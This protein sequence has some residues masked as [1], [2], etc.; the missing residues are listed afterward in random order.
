MNI[1]SLWNIEPNKFVSIVPGAELK[2]CIE[3][4]V[5]YCRDNN[6]SALLEFNGVTNPIES[7]IDAK[8]LAEIWYTRPKDLWYQEQ[9]AKNRNDKLNQLGV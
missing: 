7:Y 9:K 1:S 3:A 8:D 5:K 6:V 2:E 4:V